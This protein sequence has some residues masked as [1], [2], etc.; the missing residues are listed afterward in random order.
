MPSKCP[1][2]NMNRKTNKTKHA[3]SP[4]LRAPKTLNLRPPEKATTFS[5][6]DRIISAS[7]P[8][9]SA[10]AARTKMKSP[11]KMRQDVGRQ[12]WLMR[13][14]M[15][16]NPD[17]LGHL[18]HTE[19]RDSLTGH[20]EF[21]FKKEHPCLGAEKRRQHKEV[22]TVMLSRNKMNITI[23][24]VTLPPCPW[25]VGVHGFG[26]TLLGSTHAGRPRP[27]CPTAVVHLMRSRPTPE[28]VYPRALLETPGF[29]LRVSY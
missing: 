16:N 18:A 19:V 6:T 9:S 2:L 11:I 4:F 5:P 15:R 28:S 21:G 8:A 24:G 29:C 12:E 27:P 14:A 3:T 13:E 1:P 10:L 20:H 26:T 17:F 23:K 25:P 7:S 22:R